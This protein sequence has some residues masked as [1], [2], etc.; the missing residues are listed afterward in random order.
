MGNLRFC[1]LKDF[2]KEEI[3]SHDAD[4]PSNSIK[5][6]IEKKRN[7][8]YSMLSPSCI[9]ALESNGIR[10]VNV[11]RTDNLPYYIFWNPGHEDDAIR[12]LDIS[13]THGGLLKDE[14]FE[15]AVEIGTILG[16]TR[17]SIDEYVFHR[18]GKHLINNVPVINEPDF[19]DLDDE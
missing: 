1:S 15:E 4:L 2:I 9:H 8:G 12:L 19:Y 10:Y 6:V 7:V 13:Q 3:D 14:S 17:R 5:T 11:P 16:Y 18:Y